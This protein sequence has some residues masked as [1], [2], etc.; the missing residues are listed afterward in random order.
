MITKVGLSQNGIQNK[1]NTMSNTVAQKQHSPSFGMV[2]IEGHKDFINLLDEGL[3]GLNLGELFDIRIIESE[4]ADSRG[5]G[6][7]VIQVIST[8]LQDL[9]DWSSKPV[10]LK[11]FDPIIDIETLEAGITEEAIFK[12]Q[13]AGKSGAEV[14]TDHDILD[15]RVSIIEAA[16]TTLEQLKYAFSSQK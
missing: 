5:L 14:N 10:T 4:N 3:S 1:Q 9:Y 12:N 7:K 6:K 16:N 8:K 2:K 15:N 11:E 13:I